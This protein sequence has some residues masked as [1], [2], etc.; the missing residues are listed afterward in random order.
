MAPDSQKKAKTE[1]GGGQISKY[2]SIITDG[3]DRNQLSTIIPTA[4]H[5]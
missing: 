3:S 1:G 5:C 4:V 2:L